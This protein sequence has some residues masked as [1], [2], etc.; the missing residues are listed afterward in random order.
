MLLVREKRGCFP[1]PGVWDGVRP[2]LLLQSIFP[3]QFIKTTVFKPDFY[4]YVCQHSWK[5]LLHM[6]ALALRIFTCTALSENH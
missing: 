3:G 1:R 2:H 6:E 4:T 5:V